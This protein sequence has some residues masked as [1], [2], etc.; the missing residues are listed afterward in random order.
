MHTTI[1]ITMGAAL[2]LVIGL[3]LHLLRRARLAA[4]RE[5]DCKA[6]NTQLQEQLTELRLEVKNQNNEFDSLNYAISHD[7]RSPIHALNGFSEALLEDHTEALDAEAIDFLQRIRKAAGKIDLYVNSLLE[8]SRLTRN[9]MNLKE[10]NLDELIKTELEDLKAEWP[11]R[12]IELNVQE[13]HNTVADPDMIGELLDTL[14]SNALKFHKST[15]TIH[16]QFGECERNGKV[17][18]FLQDDGVGF[19]MRYHN[20]LF[21]AFQRLHTE[22][23][24]SGAGMGL[25]IARKIVLKHH[26]EIWAESQLD[27]GSTFYFRLY[28]PKPHT[29]N[30][31]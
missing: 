7:L 17:Y 18:Y 5:R 16:I 22:E 13:T 30:L 12:D 31:A 2:L 21:G 26:G 6:A 10:V 3:C 4:A 23:E 29:D 27:L 8:L 24:F 14:L 20:R 9:E 25:A 1:Y 28:C 11:D 15:E 19:E